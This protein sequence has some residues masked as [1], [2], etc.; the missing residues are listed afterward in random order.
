MSIA[1]IT[2]SLIVHPDPE[3]PDLL[4][5]VGNSEVELDIA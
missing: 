1:K 3:T 5:L 2:S 4:G